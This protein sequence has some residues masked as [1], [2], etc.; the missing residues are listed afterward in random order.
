[1]PIGSSVLAAVFLAIASA[2]APAAAQQRTLGPS[3]GSVRIQQVQVAFIG[4]GEVGGG[5]LKFGGR[6][7]G[8]TVG[9]V[10]F[11]ASRMTASGTVY[12][13][14]RLQDFTGAY[15]QLRESWALG[16]QGKGSVW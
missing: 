5:T 12:G 1:M 13:L 10:G 16:A 7:Y 15:V 3:T 11:G 14:H 6:S 4:S 9:G 8:I 2:A